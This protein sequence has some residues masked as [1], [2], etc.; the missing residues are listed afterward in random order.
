MSIAEGG[1]SAPARAGT[2]KIIS[3]FL[4]GLIVYHLNFT[5]ISQIDA[6]P[7][8]Y[9]AWN[10]VNEGTFDLTSRLGRMEPYKGN[11]VKLGRNG[12]WIAR[13]PPGSALMAAPLYALVSIFHRDLPGQEGMLLVGKSAAAFYCAL[14]TALVFMVTRTVF[15]KSGIWPAILFGFGTTVYSTASQSL[16]QHGPAVF[17]VCV[18]L[19]ILLRKKEGLSEADGIAA[20]LALGMGV[21]C[22]PTL[23]VLFLP[24]WASVLAGGK[25]KCA[26]GMALAGLVPVSFLVLYNLHYS[27]SWIA[28]GYEDEVMKWSTPFWLGFLGLTV[29]PSRGLFF[30]APA[31]VIAL[32]GTYRLFKGAKNLSSMNHTIIMGATLGAIGTLFLYS[33]WHAWPG[34]WCYGPRY[35]TKT[36]PVL[37]L[38]FALGY[39]ALPSP[40]ARSGAKVLVCLSIAV[41]LIGVFGNDNIWN[42]RHYLPPYS[43][44]L[45]QF[46]DNQIAS[47]FIALIERVIRMMSP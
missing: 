44:D 13:Y 30:F 34:G 33:K 28:G 22:R 12:R 8:C 32:Y 45:F 31:S 43:M 17:W 24:M 42:A 4:I 36:M 10:L 21:V 18:V 38:L 19:F 20:G 11:M 41:H 5:H 35:L 14:A 47:A 25:W 27:G 15:P 3:L 16:W 2:W 23:A 7:A 40:R 26:A 46:G 29:A 9:T 6:L 37:A 1:D 39:E